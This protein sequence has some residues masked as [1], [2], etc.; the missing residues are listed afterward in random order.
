MSIMDRPRP[1]LDPNGI[2]VIWWIGTSTKHQ[3]YSPLVQFDWCWKMSLENNFYPVAILRVPGHSRSYIFYQDAANDIPAY[4]QLFSI[5]QRNDHAKPKYLL[6]QA[7]DR[8]GR[9]ALAVQVE[10]LCDEL[11]CKIWSGRIGRPVESTVGQIFASG[12]EPHDGSRRDPPNAGT[13]AWCS[14]KAGQ[15]EKTSL[16]ET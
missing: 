7:R 15:R 4:R 2:P 13:A 3:K 11:G 12:M 14:S 6:T 16:R 9:N 5:L 8:L 1:A 10:A